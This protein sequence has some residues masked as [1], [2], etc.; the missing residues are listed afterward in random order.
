MKGYNVCLDYVAKLRSCG[1][2][3][4]YKG[5]KKIVKSWLSLKW[6]T[7]YPKFIEKAVDFSKVRPI[8]IWDAWL[9]NIWH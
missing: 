3:E 1:K 2:V 6:K 8:S 4:N 5:R 7:L 9:V